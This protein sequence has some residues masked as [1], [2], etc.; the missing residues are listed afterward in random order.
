VPGKR[1]RSA[2]ILNCDARYLESQ[3]RR[4]HDAYRCVMSYVEN[5]HRLKLR[6]TVPHRQE[7]PHRHYR[8]PPFTSP[9]TGKLPFGRFLYHRGL[10]SYHQLIDALVWQKA[11]RPKFGE[12]AKGMQF[13]V[14]PEI[15]TI[16]RERKD[17]ERFGDTAYRLGLL[18][19]HE[20]ERLANYQRLIQPR[21]GKYFV[22]R[23]ILTL[24]EIERLAWESK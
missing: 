19:R 4:V 11:S 9:T 24:L 20:I 2:A 6:G 12:L 1:T 13:L 23:G 16:L 22:E 7:R 8:T 3:F 10:I 5:P 18:T 15:L 17:G 14:D 21:I